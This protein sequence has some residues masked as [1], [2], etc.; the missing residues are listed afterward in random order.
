MLNR[1][2]PWDAG[3]TSRQPCQKP[4]T[5]VR[6]IGRV[7]RTVTPEA[8]TKTAFVRVSVARYRDG[9]RARIPGGESW[10]VIVPAI[11]R[12]VSS[13]RSGPEPGGMMTSVQYGKARFAVAN[14]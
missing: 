7:C 10:I 6:L 13:T 14:M 4:T 11:A 8:L 12:Q 9:D 1:P 2:T 3:E 5:A